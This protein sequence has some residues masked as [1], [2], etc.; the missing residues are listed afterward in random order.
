MSNGYV[1]LTE[2]ADFSEAQV[3]R[4]FLIAQGFSPKVRDEQMRTVAPHLSNL[5][6]KLTI[7]IPEHEFI[8]ASQALEKMERN[9]HVVRDNEVVE[10]T[11][12]GF[13][14]I[15]EDTTA[16]TQSLSKKALANAILGC[17]LVPI[18]CSIFSIRLIYRVV[19]QEKPLTPK[20]RYN[21]LWALM[22]NTIGLYFWLTAGPKFLKDYLHF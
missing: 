13:V 16:Y 15:Q 22:F 1:F 18:I 5:L 10:E 20:S 17:I 19:T 14:I 21:I 2:C 3:V 12:D 9:L 8:E 4:S 11:E 6:G 7:D